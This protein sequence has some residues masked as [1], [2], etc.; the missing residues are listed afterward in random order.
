MSYQKE[1]NAF[2]SKRQSLILKD[3]NTEEEKLACKKEYRKTRIYALMDLINRDGEIISPPEADAILG[4]MLCNCK[5]SKCLEPF[6][7][8]TFKQNTLFALQGISR[9]SKVKGM[10]ERYSEIV[11]REYV[12][13]YWKLKSM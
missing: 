2:V 13:T 5:P 7:I 9:F 4:Y 10:S 3:A 1:V 11:I 6:G 12:D 8:C